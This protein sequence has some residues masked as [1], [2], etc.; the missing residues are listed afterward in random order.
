MFSKVLYRFLLLKLASGLHKRGE[1]YKEEIVLGQDHF[2]LL[3]YI[4][5]CEAQKGYTNGVTKNVII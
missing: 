5:Y 2:G 4:L 3:S 1:N